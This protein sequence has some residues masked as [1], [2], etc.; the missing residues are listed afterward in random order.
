MTKFNYSLIQVVKRGYKR[1]RKGAF[2]WPV[3]VQI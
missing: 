1:P 3:K 2:L